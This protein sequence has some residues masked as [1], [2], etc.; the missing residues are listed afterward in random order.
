MKKQLL[1]CTIF[2]LLIPALSFAQEKEEKSP[3]N[4]K[5]FSDL[6]MRNIGPGFA[7]GRIADIAIHPKDDNVWYLAVG[8]GGV[9]KTTNAGTTWDPLFDDEPSYSTGCITIDPNNPHTIWVGT[10]ENVGGR[11]VGYGDGIYRSTDD[12]KSWTNMGLKKTEHISKIIVHPEDSDILWV[13]AQGPLWNKGDERG[14]YK[15]TDG[16]KEWKKILGDDEWI[17]V[18]DVLMDPRD[19]NWLYAATWQRHRS[20]A[21]YM[22]GGPGSGIHRSSDGGET[23]EKMTSGI[24]K[25]NLGKIGIA[26][27]HHNPDILYAA[28]ELDRKKGGVFMSTNR[29]TSW[30]KQSDAVS[31]ATGPHYYQELYSSP[32][33]DG[34]LYLMDVRIQV[35]DDHGKTFR[36]LSEREKHSDNHAIVFRDD[37][38]DYLLIGTDGGIYESF[39]LGKNW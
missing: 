25:S 36:R 16:G 38:P 33:Q 9:W 39:D 8:S 29:G 18:T 11:H 37:D 30:V 35:S 31:G 28:I 24:P 3:M 14:L 10:G 19:P 21:A 32:H 20:V 13:A 27:S 4:P 7:S 5:T 34:R 22:G 15:T 2:L 6:K 23:W 1:Q 12:G 17:G 26:L